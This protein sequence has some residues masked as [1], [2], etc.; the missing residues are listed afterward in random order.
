[1]KQRCTNPK[2]NR[3][4]HYGGRSIAP[5]SPPHKST[6]G[7]IRRGRTAY[8]IRRWITLITNEVGRLEITA[9]REGTFIAAT[10]PRPAK[11]TAARWHHA[12]R[13]AEHGAHIHGTPIAVMYVLRRLYSAS[14]PAPPRKPPIEGGS[15]GSN[16][17]PSCAST[18]RNLNSIECDRLNCGGS[19]QNR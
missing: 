12:P 9:R 16:A 8:P 15:K 13:G 17:I 10:L 5:P 2:L 4:K 18:H 1:M 7:P 6:G 3:F 11:R 19:Q 14:C